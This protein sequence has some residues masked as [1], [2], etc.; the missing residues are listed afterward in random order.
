MS[1]KVISLSAERFLAVEL[2]WTLQAYLAFFYG[3][4]HVRDFGAAESESLF[5]ST[6]GLL[7]DGG[8]QIGPRGI[9]KRRL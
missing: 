3:A 6:P 4:M 8:N 1:P 2:R 9:D 7:L 5:S